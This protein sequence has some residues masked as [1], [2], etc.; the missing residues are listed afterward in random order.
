[1]GEEYVGWIIETGRIGGLAVDASWFMHGNIS[2][3]VLVGVVMVRDTEL[4][5]TGMCMF[6]L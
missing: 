5:D 1:M 3:G 2:A 6:D 4:R